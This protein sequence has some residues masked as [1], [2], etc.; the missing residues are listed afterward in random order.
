MDQV[1]FIKHINL[2]FEKKKPQQFN[3][4]HNSLYLTLFNFWNHSK[5]KK[6]IAIFR[7]ETMELSFIKSTKT[8]YKCLH[9]LVKWGFI[10]Y[11]PSK[12]KYKSS[13]IKI[14]RFKEEKNHV[15]TTSVF[16]TQEVT[17]TC[18]INATTG[19][20]EVTPNTNIIKLYKTLNKKSFIKKIEDYFKE[21]GIPTT[22]A[23]LFYHYYQAAGWKRGNQEIEDWEAAAKFWI[24]KFQKDNA[25]KP[26]WNLHINEDKDYSIPL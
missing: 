15:S 11:Q 24:L 18:G 1:N 3:A 13:L 25:N 10:L 12:S 21:N 19:K 8:Y 5:F 7:E 14:R 26:G 23:Q 4:F 22:E 16:A 2:Y 17:P 20:K 6:E 9:E